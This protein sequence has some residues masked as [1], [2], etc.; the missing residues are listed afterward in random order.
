S[1]SGTDGRC[2]IR[3]PGMALDQLRLHVARWIAVH[4]QPGPDAVSPE[5]PGAGVVGEGAV[6]SIGELILVAWVVNR[7]DQLDSVV[8]VAR[9]QIRGSDVDRVLVGTLEGIDP[10]MLEEAAN[11]RDHADVLRDALDSGPQRA[12][13][14][15]VEVHLHAG[16]RRPIESTDAGRI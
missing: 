12:D 14:P 9:H 15:D 3:M 5:L 1:R 16:L 10:R 2:L 6:E 13:A 7:C 4:G 8:E 11:H